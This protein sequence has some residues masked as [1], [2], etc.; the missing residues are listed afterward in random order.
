MQ[1]VLLVCKDGIH[2]LF[3]KAAHL[4]CHFLS[5]LRHFWNIWIK[6][7]GEVLN[8]SKRYSQNIT[9]YSKACLTKIIR[10]LIR[11]WWSCFKFKSLDWT[12]SCFSNYILVQISCFTTCIL[13]C[14]IINNI[15]FLHIF[16]SSQKNRRLMVIFVL[17]CC[18]IRI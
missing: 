11:A 1:Q 2:C 4:N 12:I 6:V 15:Y 8:F 13:M 18:S 7:E 17:C 5:Q 16:T 9:I 10:W 3:F 14:L